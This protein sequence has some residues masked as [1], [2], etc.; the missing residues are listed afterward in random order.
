M[1]ASGEAEAVLLFSLPA[2]SMTSIAGGA[3]APLGAGGALEIL[4]APQAAHDLVF[5]RSGA[6]VYPLVGQPVL[7]V[8]LRR[9]LFS[10]VDA[11]DAK[12]LVV[13]LSGSVA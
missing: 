3:A 8:S 1:E 9:Y 2:C 7:R 11:G 12:V 5:L 4:S 6:F 10:G 13:S